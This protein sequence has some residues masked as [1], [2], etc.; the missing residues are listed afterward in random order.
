MR[1]FSDF[2]VFHELHRFSL[3]I[4]GRMGSSASQN[5]AKT[6][7]FFSLASHRLPTYSEIKNAIH[8]VLLR[9]HQYQYK[10]QRVW[11]EGKKNIYD[12]AFS[13]VW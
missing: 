12:R 3:F 6:A 2:F 5:C 9:F 13:A 10:L 1:S 8:T 11:Q 7:H 4:N